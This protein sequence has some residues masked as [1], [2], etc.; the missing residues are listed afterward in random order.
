MIND[1]EVRDAESRGR[2]VYALR[3]FAEGEFIFRRRH[4]RVVSIEELEQA[5]TLI[6]APTQLIA[7][8]SAGHELIAKGRRTAAPFLA[9]LPA[10]LA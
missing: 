3:R 10:R 9:E 4:A 6:P 7:V 8:E 2:G 5:I 1:V